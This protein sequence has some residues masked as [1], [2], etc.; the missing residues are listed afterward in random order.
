MLQSTGTPSHR[1]A[2]LRLSRTQYVRLADRQ[3][4]P[5]ALV[6]EGSVHTHVANDCYDGFMLV[7]LGTNTKAFL[8]DQLRQRINWLD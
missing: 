6:D 7:S 3:Y 4:H 1:D 8:R 2:G 5:T